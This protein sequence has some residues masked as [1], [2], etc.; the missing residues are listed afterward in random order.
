M[1]LVVEDG[2]IVVG[3][4]SYVTRSELIA[5]ALARGVTLADDDGTDVLAIKAMDFLA[6]TATRWRGEPT[7]EEQELDWPRR[8]AIPE[9]GNN[10]FPDTKIPKEI[11]KAQM[12]LAIVA[13]SGVTL[14]P[15]TSGETAFVTKEKVD[16]LETEYSEAVALAL[17]GKLPDMPNV[18]ALLSKWIKA[19]LSLTTRRV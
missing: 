1:A 3:A 18:T 10:A 17:M 4:N 12:E 11:I 13:N 16:V 19:S 15:T 14:I 9:G 2:S 6:L 7:S 5:Y 8:G